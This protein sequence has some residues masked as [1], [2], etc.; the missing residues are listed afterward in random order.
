[1]SFTT[2]FGSFSGS[3]KN[4]KL[5]SQLP[6]ALWRICSAFGLR[7]TSGRCP[8]RTR[9]DTMALGLVGIRRA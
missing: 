6:Q 4:R 9:G 7:Q 1:M 2:R 3:S 8:W 5:H